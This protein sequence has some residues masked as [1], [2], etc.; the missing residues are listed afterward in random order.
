MIPIFDNT[1]YQILNL[2]NTSKKIIFQGKRTDN[3][4]WAEG[5][6]FT[7]AYSIG[8]LEEYWA[9]MIKDIETGIEY[10]VHG[11]T[12]SIYLG[13]DDEDG[14]KIFLHDVVMYNSINHRAAIIFYDPNILS[15]R[16][17]D[18]IW[19]KSQDILELKCSKI[20]RLGS[21]HDLTD[22]QIKTVIQG[23]AKF[24]DLFKLED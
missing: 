10:E 12:V 16:M 1:E 24:I 22:D 17:F 4:K 7:K 13:F 5:Y 19:Q 15:L 21:A 20:R 9:H 14:N 8:T 6:Y 18:D 2:L 11:N 3:G 23:E